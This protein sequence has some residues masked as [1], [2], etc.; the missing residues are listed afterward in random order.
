MLRTHNLGEVDEK[1]AGSK[2]SLCGWIDSI[3]YFKSMVFLVLRDRYGKVQCIIPKD[4]KGF[5]NAKSLTLE[6]SIK[7]NGEVKARPKGQE[8]KDMG[9]QGGIEINVD[10]LEIFNLC[11]KMPFDLKAENSEEIR[12][13]YRFLDLRTE[14]M[15][16]N[17]ILRGKITSA[18]LEFFEKEGFV[19][20]ETP[21]LAKST[22]EGA[23]DFLV[24]SR[25]EKGKV[26]ALPQSPQIFKQLSQVAGFDK[27]IQIPRCFRDE[28]SRKDRQPEFT[29]VDVEMSFIE[30]DD[31]INIL[32]R[33]LKHVFKKVLNKE[34]KTPFKRISY[35]ESMKKYGR[36]NPD[37]RKN[38]NDVNE[39]AFC[40]I[41][42]FPTFEYSKED[43]RYKSVHHPFT[44]PITGKKGKLD[45]NEKSKSK[46]YD[47][48]L[49]G[50]EIGG[51]SIRIH[52]SEVQSK[53]FDILKISKEEAKKKFGFLLNAL[54]F[55]AP[56]HGGI[57]LG[58]DRLVQLMAGEDNIRE[59]IAFPKNKE[60]RDVMMDSP[61]DVYQ[62]QLDEV[63]LE[64]KNKGKKV[65]K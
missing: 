59:V 41:V 30:E 58:M 5:E 47:V 52:D 1:L 35:D 28:D 45:F 22:P 2:V 43:K 44:T 39:F 57:A 61:S 64:F 34:I 11:P 10:E 65:K 37:L 36:D 7:I 12:L 14:K 42:D 56:P 16:K 23:R 40:W 50:S 29:Q 31:I 3:R 4:S 54:Q 9:K 49:N 26:Y 19:N 8:N 21:I 53:V 17:I 48:V 24:P 13:E 25:K 63:G 51:G 20:I 32:E 6:S 62:E 60:A 38:K 15:Q 18:V 55:G 27:Y 33:M 46:A